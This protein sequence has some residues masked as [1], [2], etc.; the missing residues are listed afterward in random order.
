MKK[1]TTLVLCGFFVFILSS[2]NSIT[3][4][5]SNCDYLCP[6]DELWCLSNTYK[7]KINK[8][9]I[10]MELWVCDGEKTH[11]YWIKME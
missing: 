1:F 6:E 10:M 7:T 9:G 8:Y 3:T 2:F 5:T 11:K 4:N